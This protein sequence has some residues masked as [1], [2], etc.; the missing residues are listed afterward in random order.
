MRF[1]FLF[2]WHEMK[3][4][5]SSKWTHGEP[6]IALRHR[7]DGAVECSTNDG[8]GNQA[9]SIGTNGKPSKKKPSTN[10]VYRKDTPWRLRKGLTELYIHN[11]CFGPSIAPV[12]PS[13]AYTS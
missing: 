8:L 10:R 4:N 2:P 9:I 3:L 6:G 1:E 12:P 11:G 13:L 7:L 5:L